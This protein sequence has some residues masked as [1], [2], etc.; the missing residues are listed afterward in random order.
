MEKSLGERLTE[1][2]VE[3]AEKF[4][5]VLGQ[6]KGKVNDT[7][8]ARMEDIYGALKNGIPDILKNGGIYRQITQKVIWNDADLIRML[9]EK[10]Y[11]DRGAYDILLT[12]KGVLEE[13][14]NMMIKASPKN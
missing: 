11:Q 9:A 10:L 5:V 1:Y 4:K 6:L 8:Y 12:A 3:G 2:V 7:H 14:V 13:I